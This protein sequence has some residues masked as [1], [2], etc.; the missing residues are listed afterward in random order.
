METS[1][2]AG[3]LHGS[4]RQLVTTSCGWNG[5]RCVSGSFNRLAATPVG[6]RKRAETCFFLVIKLVE[7]DDMNDR[8]YFTTTVDEIR[9]CL[10]EGLTLRQTAERLNCSI[11]GLQQACS[12]LQELNVKTVRKEQPARVAAHDPFSICR[13]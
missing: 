11:Q 8:K 13:H 9:A 6:G 3:Y 12:L 10:Q 1:E 4:A 2:N 5:I 7:A